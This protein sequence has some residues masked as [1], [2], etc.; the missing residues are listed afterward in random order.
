MIRNELDDLQLYNVFLVRYALLKIEIIS[1]LVI[2]IKNYVWWKK[3]HEIK[4]NLENL[5]DLSTTPV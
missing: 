5:E 1:H 3:T 4:S 2:H